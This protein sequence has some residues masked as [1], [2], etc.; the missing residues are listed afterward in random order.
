[1][2]PLS[3]PYVLPFIGGGNRSKS[4]SDPSVRR[5]MRL[6]PG[7]VTARL[8]VDFVEVVLDGVP[9]LLGGGRGGG[10]SKVRVLD[11]ESGG[12]ERVLVSGS[13]SPLPLCSEDLCICASG[14]GAMV[15]LLIWL[16]LR[17]GGGVGG[18]N[19]FVLGS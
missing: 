7:G 15:L 18:G 6:P 4:T 11:I 19:F 5:R 12:S 9:R 2:L 1:M 16:A 10:G 17:G 3:L 14:L 13:N 8:G